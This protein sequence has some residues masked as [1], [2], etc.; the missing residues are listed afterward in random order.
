MRALALALLL[1]GCG[2]IPFMDDE[3]KVPKGS[4]GYVSGFYGG[5]SADEPRA[6][7]A[8]RDV[9]TAGGTAVDAA[10]AMYFT[11]A[12]T[13]PSAAGLGGGGICLVRDPDTQIVKTLD[14]L[15]QPSSGQGRKV[16]VPGNPRG[17]FALHTKFGTLRWEKLV[18]PA[19]NMARFGSQV[20]RAFAEDIRV[21]S[22]AI[23]TSSHLRSVF[24]DRQGVPLSE[25]KRLK[26][27]ELATFL[28]RLRAH[29]AGVLYSGIN[30]RQIIRDAKRA[31]IGLTYR[32]LV[33]ARPA[34]RSTIRIPF[35][36]NT[37]LHFAMP[38]TSSGTLGAKVAAA[39]VADE[40]YQKAKV[41][42]K[43]HLMAEA[44]QRAIADGANGFKTVSIKRQIWSRKNSGEFKNVT[45][46]Q[47]DDS[48]AEK[49][50]A[51]Y[52]PGRLTDIAAGTPKITIRS[53]EGGTTSFS[54]I[55]RSGGAVACALTMN[56]AFGTGEAIP[57]TGLILANPP[58]S[59]RHR[60][61]SMG[62]VLID[63]NF[64]SRVY[65]AGAASGD[66]SSQAV[67]AQLAVGVA[68]DPNTT[69]ENKIAERRRVFRDP[70]SRT[71]YVEQGAD[72]GF[73]NSLK[74]R[75][76][77][78][79]VASGLSRINMAYCRSGLP[80]DEAICSIEGDPRG[81]GFAATPD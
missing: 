14:F 3:P 27:L 70:A 56:G 29:G 54:A 80:A 62:A 37:S 2:S 75:G 74:S 44:V 11:L 46:T 60:D 67:L 52:Q 8:G 50:M 73:V 28:A 24:A 53:R 5:V 22:N 18:Q 4:T 76:H 55:D 7:I 63:H 32:D 72:A 65:M 13:M 31:G 42:D 17:I 48:Y 9:L 1:G 23:T 20:S 12:V 64:R 38:R 39:L 30:A 58:T 77:R 34:W 10:T 79:A 26:Q 41:G 35:V 15:G 19:E 51:G 16:T 21:S 6:A 81:F 78:V 66:A 25:G 69:L 49:L 59:V 71:T 61:L 68:L 33:A 36:A 47:L 40:R 45:Y 57:G 43:G